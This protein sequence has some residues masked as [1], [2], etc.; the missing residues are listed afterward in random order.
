MYF[1]EKAQAAVEHFQSIFTEP[2]GCPK[3]D[4]LEVLSLFPRSITNEMNEELTKVIMEEEIQ[5]VLHSF[6]N[7]KIPSPD[8][9]TL[10][11]FIGFYGKIKEDILAVVKEYWKSRKVLGSFNSTFITPIPKKHKTKTFDDFMPIACCNMIY[12]VIAKM[13]SQRVK[14]VMSKII[15]EEQ[16]GFLHNR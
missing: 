16:F 15:S 11:F 4:I 3:D 2:E 9:F 6:Q 1:P 13:I 7:R 8:G 10:E 14:P 12:K 5:Q